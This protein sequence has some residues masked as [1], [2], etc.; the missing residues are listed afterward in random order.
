MLRTYLTIALRQLK[1]GKLVS[2]INIAGLAVAI[3]A[4]YFIIAYASFELSFEDFHA[5]RES[6]YRVGLRQYENGMLKNES[7]KSYPGVYNFLNQN[8]PEVQSATRFMKIPANTGFLFG[9]KDKMFNEWGGVINADT[10]FF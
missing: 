8:I 1:K 4:F 2:S 5:N 7:A 9:Y 6:V 10:N 3:A